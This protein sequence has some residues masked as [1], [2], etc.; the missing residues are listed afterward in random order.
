[1]NA[2]TTG[3]PRL[4][5]CGIEGCRICRWNEPGQ[6]PRAMRPPHVRREPPPES[7]A[8]TFLATAALV[9]LLVAGFLLLIAAQPM[10]QP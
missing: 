7:L 2:I 6:P 8:S 3:T 1:M 4:R 9:V 5:P 10:V